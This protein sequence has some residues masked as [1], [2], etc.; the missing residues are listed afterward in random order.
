MEGSRGNSCDLHC[1]SFIVLT[2]VIVKTYPFLHKIYT[3]CTQRIAYNTS[4]VQNT[5]TQ[6][7]P[8]IYCLRGTPHTRTTSPSTHPAHYTPDRQHTHLPPSRFFESRSFSFQTHTHLH[9]VS[10]RVA[11]SAFSAAML[12]CEAP[13]SHHWLNPLGAH[14]PPNASCVGCVFHMKSG[15]NTQHT[16]LQCIAHC[17]CW[18]SQCITHIGP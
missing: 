13:I 12:C 6:H 2:I 7:T 1:R 9:G 3:A 18:S 5:D 16:I 8:D 10:F 15:G 14:S 11:A 4:I 17:T